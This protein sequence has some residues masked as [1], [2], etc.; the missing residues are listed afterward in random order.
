MENPTMT[1][2]QL[3]PDTQTQ[4]LADVEPEH[5]CTHGNCLNDST[6]SS[7]SDTNQNTISLNDGLIASGQDSPRRVDNVV[8]M[9]PDSQPPDSPGTSP[10][11]A[12]RST[13]ITAKRHP[14]TPRTPHTTQRKRGRPAKTMSQPNPTRT[15][16]RNAKANSNIDLNNLMSTV[17]DIQTTVNTL[18]QLNDTNSELV[19]QLARKTADNEE[20]HKELNDLRKTVNKLKEVKHAPQPN[21][22][23]LI[24]GSSIIRDIDET[25]LIDT[26]V[27][28][29]R[30]GKI[31]T[32]HNKL[33]KK[34]EK[35]DHIY[36]QVASN[37]CAERDDVKLISEDY[38]LLIKTAKQLCNSLTVSS[39]TP[40]LNDL[41]VQERINQ[42]NGFL[43]CH[44]Q[45]EAVTF[46]DNDINF[47][48][49]DE[50]INNGYL[51]P[52]KLHLSDAG[53][54][55]LVKNLKLKTTCDDVTLPRNK[56]NSPQTKTSR[57]EHQPKNPPTTTS[58]LTS[59]NT[60]QSGYI[61]TNKPRSMN[62]YTQNRNSTNKDMSCNKCGESHLPSTCWHPTAVRCHF[63]KTI[64][65]KQS[66]CPNK[67]N[68][69]P[70]ARGHLNVMK[71]NHYVNRVQSFEYDHQNNDFLGN[72][73][74]SVLTHY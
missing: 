8:M 33:L 19:K 37:D 20:L 21:P 34:K 59:T 7:D 36:L 26:E 24:I 10:Q 1:L 22:K 49:R 30:G 3:L 51:C 4:A 42:L 40:R 13:R 50:S 28:C 61:N 52:D 69:I 74:F 27:D 54:N 32:I 23:S 56:R 25:K 14:K 43:L 63:C 58:T 62:T 65:H 6:V 39:V 60:R 17:L 67:P 41:T 55:S 68:D 9:I 70:P 57:K 35:Y 12:R 31:A 48:L 2:T 44:C 73:R 71:D 29:I 46:N 47:K 45:D 72:N 64:G 53:T 16:N 5:I 11:P 38:A 18:K 66:R 15:L